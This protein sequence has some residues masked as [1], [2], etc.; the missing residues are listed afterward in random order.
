MSNQSV[1]PL[2]YILVVDSLQKR[3]ITNYTIA[4]GNECVW[5]THYRRGFA[6]SDYYIFRDGRIVDIV[7]D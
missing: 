6:I 5:V 2:E 4:Q 7:T 3:G 1:N